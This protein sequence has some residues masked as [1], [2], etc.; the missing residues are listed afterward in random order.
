MENKNL[1]AAVK[2][3]KVV[4]TEGVKEVKVNEATNRRNSRGK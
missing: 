4:K 2:D 1:N 3:E